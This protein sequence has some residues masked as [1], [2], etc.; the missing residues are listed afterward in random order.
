MRLSSLDWCDP[1]T[2]QL[3]I[4]PVSAS[5]ILTVLS[6]DP[7]TTHL[8]SCENVTEFIPSMGPL[9][10]PA[11]EGLFSAWGLNL[12]PWAWMA[13]FLRL[14]LEDDTSLLRA[15]TSLPM[16]SIG[17][18]FVECSDENNKSGT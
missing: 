2:A 9:K 18:Q 4:S 13:T 3:T 10:G 8:P 11:A 12:E 16:H 6:F 7:E 15:S 5:Q 1:Q 14:E 17:S